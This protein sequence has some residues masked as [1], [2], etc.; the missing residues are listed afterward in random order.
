M[1]EEITPPDLS[2]ERAPPAG[3]TVWVEHVAWFDRIPRWIAMI[4][5]ALAVLLIWQGVTATG[6]V[7][8]IILPTPAETLRD[9][10]FVGSNL[11]GGDYMLTALWT[12]TRTVIYGFLMALFSKFVLFDKTSSDQ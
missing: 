5:L 10:I 7:S 11:I 12:T 2:S 4:G 8:P 9:L 6:I 3:E 1:T